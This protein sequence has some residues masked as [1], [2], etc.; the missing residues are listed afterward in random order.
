MLKTVKN[1][2]IKSKR[3]LVRADFNV[4]LDKK[5]F[6]EDDFRLEQAIPTIKYLIQNKAKIILMS[7]L[8]NP[9]GKVVESLRLTPIQEKLKE[10]LSINIIKTDDC[11][12]EKVENKIKEM[13]EGEILLL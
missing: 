12:G 5:G 9:Q 10:Y 4:P 3:I 11:I 7:H 1:I 8:G 2:E 6:I 13:N